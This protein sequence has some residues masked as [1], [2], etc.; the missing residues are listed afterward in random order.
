[1]WIDG[2]AV[3]SKAKEHVELFN[4]VCTLLSLKYLCVYRRQMKL[5]A[6]FQNAQKAKWKQPLNRV[7]VHIKHGEQH[8]LWQGSNVCFDLR[9]LYVKI[10]FVF[11]LIFAKFCLF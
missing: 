1:M 8:L 4:P 7:T 6:T 5:S 9:Q 3:E 2:K 11:N 10:W